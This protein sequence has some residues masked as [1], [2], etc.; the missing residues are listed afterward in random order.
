[1]LKCLETL[2][3]GDFTSLIYRS[4]MHENSALKETPDFTASI[5]VCSLLKYAHLKKIF[6]SFAFQDTFKIL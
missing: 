1:M 5:A 6:L 3:H 2:L 4:S